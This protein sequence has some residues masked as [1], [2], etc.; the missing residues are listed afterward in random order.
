[1]ALEHRA[2]EES[3]A[4]QGDARDLTAGGATQLSPSSSCS[5]GY[6]A[7]FPSDGNWT[8][9]LG[10]NPPSPGVSHSRGRGFD[11]PRLHF[12]FCWVSALT[13]QPR[14]PTRVYSARSLRVLASARGIT[15]AAPRP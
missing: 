1:P 10:S 4:G 12:R 14:P 8:P 11:S 6:P 9:V 13:A 2:R 15:G 5:P 3:A 7:N